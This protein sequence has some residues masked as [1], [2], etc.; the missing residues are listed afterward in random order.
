M[1]KFLINKP[2]LG[3]FLITVFSILCSCFITYSFIY[4]ARNYYEFSNDVVT[5]SLIL[6]VINPLLIVPFTSTRL[7]KFTCDLKDLNE[8]LDYAN[9]YDSLTKVY[10]RKY[11][12]TLANK[13]FD[14][15]KIEKTFFSVFIL[16]YDFFKNINDTYGH[17]TGDIVLR[18]LSSIVS[19]TVRKSD[20]FGRYG[21][22]EF[23]LICP[24][25]N[26]EEAF[27]LAEKI[28]KEVNKVYEINSHKITMSISIGFDTFNVD[29]KNINLSKLIS[30]ADK[31]LYIAKENGRNQVQPNIK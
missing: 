6:A 19:S 31:A 13:Y 22:E 4:F 30:N 29:S 25:T 3:T 10:N 8:K 20:I 27:L 23:L 1:E 2:I 16:D 7:M 5:I 17:D 9:R 21:G 18:K 26:K 28:R 24:N 15:A 12:L 14:L 11:T